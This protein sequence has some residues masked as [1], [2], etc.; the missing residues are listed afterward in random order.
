[1]KFIPVIK[2]KFSGSLLQCHMMI[3]Q[4]SL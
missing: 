4:K 3:L 1:V 2:A